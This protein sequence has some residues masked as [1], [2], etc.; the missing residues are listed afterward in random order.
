M[1]ERGKV[2]SWASFGYNHGLMSQGDKRMPKKQRNS[3]KTT[4][5]DFQIKNVLDVAG[6]CLDNQLET[7]SFSM[8]N[9]ME[10]CSL[11]ASEDITKYT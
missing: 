7:L 9:Y 11:Y 4:G 1:A 5:K 10:P 3:S 2:I 6:D 8:K